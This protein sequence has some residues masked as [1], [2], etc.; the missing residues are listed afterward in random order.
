MT[1]KTNEMAKLVIDRLI[2]K[3]SQNNN[4]LLPWEIIFEHVMGFLRTDPYDSL[5]IVAVK[6]LL[7]NEELKFIK[8]NRS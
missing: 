7:T 1:K 3:S 6:L 4:M 5:E 8:E 2:H